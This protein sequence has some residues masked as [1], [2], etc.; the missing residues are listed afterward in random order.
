VYIG[1]PAAATA[2]CPSLQLERGPVQAPEQP[3]AAVAGG[4]R[5]PTPHRIAQAGGQRRLV[6]GGCQTW[7]RGAR[8]RAGPWT[9][10]A[11]PGPPGARLQQ[12]AG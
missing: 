9:R 3:A 10:L 11:W 7:R 8:L 1:A 12:Q 4:Q 6:H 2:G 5:W